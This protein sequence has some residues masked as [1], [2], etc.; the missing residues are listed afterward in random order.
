[1]VVFV[2]KAHITNNWMEEP[3]QPANGVVLI[4]LVT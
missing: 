2:T 4:P 3:N 1:M